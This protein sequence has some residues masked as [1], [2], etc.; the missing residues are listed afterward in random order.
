MWVLEGEERE[1]EIENQ[2]E[3]IMAEIFLNLK[4]INIKAQETENPKE[5]KPKEVHTKTHHG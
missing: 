2:F 4:E 3:K 5:D 1:Q